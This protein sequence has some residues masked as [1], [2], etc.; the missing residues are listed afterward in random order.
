MPTNDKS[1]ACEGRVIREHL[2]L[3]RACGGLDARH[4][5]CGMRRAA[6]GCEWVRALNR[7]LSRCRK[8]NAATR[9]EPIGRQQ[10]CQAKICHAFDLEQT[11]NQGLTHHCENPKKERLQLSTMMKETI[12]NECSVPVLVLQ[13]LRRPLCGATFSLSNGDD[14]WR[15]LNGCRV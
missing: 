11:K 13:R 9:D 6:L 2:D 12:S 1:G 15:G 10:R 4:L 3:N 14:L 8:L 5:S 7:H